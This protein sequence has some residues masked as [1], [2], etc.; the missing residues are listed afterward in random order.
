MIITIDGPVASGKTTVGKLLAAQLGFDYLYSGLLYRAIAYVLVHHAACKVEDLPTVD[1][2][3]VKKAIAHY[4]INYHFLEHGNACISVNGESVDQQLLMTPEIDKAASMLGLN[5]YIR[6]F[7][8]EMQ[9][10]LVEHRNVIVDGRD[11][12]VAVFPEAQFKFFLTALVV[13]RA[14]RYIKRQ[15]E[16]GN[17]CSLQQ[18]ERVIT[19][20]DNRDNHWLTSINKIK[21]MLIVDT[22][23]MDQNSVAAYLLAIVQ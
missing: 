20:R 10:S 9:R 7:L 3:M 4:Y 14:Q 21:D 2:V 18:A 23:S 19:E 13:I 12:G 1:D 22:S 11:A 15:K 16:L 8:T 5:A 17:A 6:A